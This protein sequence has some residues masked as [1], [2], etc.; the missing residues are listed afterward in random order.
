MAGIVTV[1]FQ[2]GWFVVGAG[3]NGMEF[4]FILIAVLLAILFQNELNKKTTNI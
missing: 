3:R 1:H 4:S 2:E